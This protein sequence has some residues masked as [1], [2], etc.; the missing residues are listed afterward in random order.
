MTPREHLNELLDRWH[1]AAPYTEPGFTRLSEIMDICVARA[2]V[3]GCRQRIMWNKQYQSWE[4]V[5]LTRQPLPP[6]VPR[7]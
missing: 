4:V 1:K 5:S 7:I 2:V 6:L 3:T